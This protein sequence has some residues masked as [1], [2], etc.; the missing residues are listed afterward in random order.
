ML[1]TG[2][3]LGGGSRSWAQMS[4]ASLPSR[5][6]SPTNDCAVPFQYRLVEKHGWLVGKFDEFI[7]KEALLGDKMPRA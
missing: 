3:K 2:L 5:T 7:F 6:A 1:I 4:W